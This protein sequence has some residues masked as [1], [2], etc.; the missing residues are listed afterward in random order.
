MTSE[1]KLMNLIYAVSALVFA[2]VVVLRFI[3]K[4]ESIPFFVQKLPALNA[5][6]NGTCTFL[7]LSS[8]YF[9][10]RKKIAIHKK[11]NITAFILSALFLA[12]YVTYHALAKET[13]FPQ[14]NPLRPL[15]LIILLSH[16]VLAALV[17]PVILI[18]FYRGLNMQVPLHRKI[19]RWAFPIWL[20]VTT[21]GVIVYLMISPF[22]SF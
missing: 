20:Y 14:D 1:K 8:Y 16:I 9:I 5:M 19:A 4:P 7:L 15:Y 10:K 21:S 18:T 12:S 22:Y 11:I 6:I 17:L 2:L 13:S 3:P